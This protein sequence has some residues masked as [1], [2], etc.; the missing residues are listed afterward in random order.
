MR[1]ATDQVERLTGK[2][3]EPMSPDRSLSSP[4][5]VASE[6]VRTSQ[7]NDP[8]DASIKEAKPS[9]IP[10]SPEIAKV[11]AKFHDKSMKRLE[12]INRRD[13]PVYSITRMSRRFTVSSTRENFGSQAST[14][15]TILKN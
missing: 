13:V 12:T 15:W 7:G 4:G 5:A 11:V 14:I 2:M 9:E 8:S 1:D 3:R 10:L 6:S